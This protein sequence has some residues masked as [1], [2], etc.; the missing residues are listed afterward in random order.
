MNP[1]YSTGTCYSK[2]YKLFTVPVVYR[3]K[4]TLN[5]TQERITGNQ[6]TGIVAPFACKRRETNY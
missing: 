4:Y 2:L 1:L 6:N 3:E 5:T